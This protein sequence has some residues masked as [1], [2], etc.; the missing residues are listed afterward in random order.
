VHL[1]DDTT[2]FQKTY[3]LVNK[4]ISNE[5]I[6][7]VVNEKFKHLILEQSQVKADNI[8][9]EPLMR[10]TAPALGLALTLIDDKYSDDT[11]ICTFPS[12]QLI[13][14]HEE[15]NLSLN[16]ACQAAYELNALIT[17]GIEPN[18]PAPHFGYIQYSEEQTD[19]K[20]NK[21]SNELFDNGVRKSI[22]FIEKPDEETAQRF[23]N[24]GGFVWNSGMLIA[25]K[26][27]IIAAYKKF[28]NYHYSKFQQ[29]KQF[30]QTENYT[31]ELENL[32]K[33]FNKISIDY[34]ILEN[35]ANIYVVKSTFT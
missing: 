35:A 6:F 1:L 25:K 13:K 31:S 21:I 29:I 10:Q 14:N 9:T 15:F 28:M 24:S 2:L 23:I 5:D 26:S 27:V 4:Q 7:V 34:G 3:H 12:D 18:A 33:T 20:N 17:I 30:Y 16:V 32:Y 8:F 19:K 22:N 11:I